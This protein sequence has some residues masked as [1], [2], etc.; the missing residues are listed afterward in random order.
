MFVP[1]VGYSSGVCLI[2]DVS[3][4]VSVVDALD[5]LLDAD[6]S[7]RA[8]LTES[9]SQTHNRARANLNVDLFEALTWPTSIEEY[10]SYLEQ[11]ARWIP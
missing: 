5:E 7:L 6:P 2:G 9:L 8:L 10:K 1:D 4:D 11:F 3:T